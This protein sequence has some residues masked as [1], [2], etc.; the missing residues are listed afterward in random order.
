MFLTSTIPQR[1]AAADYRAHLGDL[2][3]NARLHG[4]FHVTAGTL[5]RYVSRLSVHLLCP[6]QADLGPW[7]RPPL[8]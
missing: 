8:K 5:A 1:T 4:A 6:W 3:A 7:R 2:L